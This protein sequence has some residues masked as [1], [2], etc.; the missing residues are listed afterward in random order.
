MQ[1]LQR[2]D[3]REST[4]IHSVDMPNGNRPHEPTQP[5]P[6]KADGDGTQDNRRG[7]QSQIVEQ[8][9]SRKHHDARRG[10]GRRCCRDGADGVFFETPRPG[11][12]ELDNLDAERDFS[13]PTLLPPSGFEFV[14]AGEG[15]GPG[16]AEEVGDEDDEGSLDCYEGWF[17]LEVGD[18]LVKLS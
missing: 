14:A 17:E 12:D 9:L 13:L 8:V 11:V 10:V 4:P 18:M 1:A 15:D 7:A 6:E 3:R 2:L 16:F 5:V